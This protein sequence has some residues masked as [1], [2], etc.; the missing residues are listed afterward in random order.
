[1][2][3]D[4]YLLSPTKRL[5]QLPNPIVAITGGIASGK[6]FVGQYLKKQNLPFI[7]AD[8]EIKEIY[9][10]SPIFDI[11]STYAPQTIKNQVVN[12]SLLRKEYF[13]NPTLK[14]K[15]NDYIYPR[16]KQKVTAF[17]LQYPK[18]QEVYYEIPLLFEQSLHTK[19]DIIIL[20]YASRETQIKRIQKR[21][22]S[23]LE[24]INKILN[25]QLPMSKKKQG[26][27]FIINNDKN[28][29]N[30]EKLNHDIQYILNTLTK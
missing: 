15:L 7:S 25:N 11:L 2:I 5:Y 18:D 4:K 14:K 28:T 6:S 26:S 22:Q 10:E 24:V 8:Q 17:S 27:T 29:P 21:D 3:K 9:K 12:F 19:V 16:L 23:S 13:N 30:R 20:V 1:M